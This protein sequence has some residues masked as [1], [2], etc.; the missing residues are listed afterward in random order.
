MSFILP[1]ETPAGCNY[2]KLTGHYKHSPCHERRF[3]FGFCFRFNQG[4]AVKAK[5]G[6]QHPKEGEYTGD[7]HE[8]SKRLNISY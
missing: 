3:R 1:R 5:K 7:A 6:Y 4:R 2:R 8:G